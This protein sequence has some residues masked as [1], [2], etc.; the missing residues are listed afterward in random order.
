MP[1]VCYPARTGSNDAREGAVTETTRADLAARLAAGGS[2]T[3][4]R[5]G[6]ALTAAEA[7]VEAGTPAPV[8]AQALA[9]LR[10]ALAAAGAE[11]LGGGD[12]Q[13][14][15]DALV[16][17][18]PDS[19][20]AEEV[21][22]LAWVAIADH[23]ARSGERPA[24][25]TTG[26]AESWAFTARSRSWP[27]A[28]PE[29]RV[30]QAAT[31]FGK[32]ARVIVVRGPGRSAFLAAL[33]RA[34]LGAHGADAIVTPVIPAA[35]DDLQ[36]VLHGLL[37][38]ASLDPQLAA[39]LDQLQLGEDLL[40]VLGRAGEKQPVALL[41][42]DAHLQSRAVLLGL[43]IF[44][45]PAG[46]RDAL[47]AVGSADDPADDGPL[48]E[49]VA[50]AADRGLLTEI[51]LP[52]FDASGAA[53]LWT[54]RFGAAPAPALAQALAEAAKPRPG[55]TPADALRVARA[56]IEDLADA[57]DPARP[58]ADAA[59]HLARGYDP[60][61]HLP[62]HDVARRV[63]A[64]AALEGETF[65]ALTVG[66][67]FQKD[68]DFI[69][70]LLFDDEHE[71]NGTPV[72][73]CAAAV[74]PG[75][76]RWT[77]LPD[78]LHPVFC[79][80]DARLAAAL[81]PVVPDN[82]RSLVAGALRD[83]L[84]E[85]YGPAGTW[86]VADRLWRLDVLAGRTRHV[87]RLLIGTFDPAR[88]EA[89]LR[90]MAPV[91]GAEKPYRLALARLFGSAMEVGSL[92]ARQ[93]N[94]PGA[95]QAFQIAAAAAQRLGRP[96]PA[97]EAL[98]RLAELRVALALPRAAEQA[99]QLADQLLD[100]AGQPL[101]RAR[102]TLL[103]AEVAV[104][105][106]DTESALR[107]LEDA[108]AKLRALG[109][110]GHVALGLSR[111]GRLVFERGDASRAESLLDEAIGEADASADARA[112]AVA[113]LTR[114]FVAGEQGQLDVAFQRLQEAARAFQEVGLPVHLVEMAAAGLQRRHGD[115]AEAEQRL[116]RVADA[117]KKGGAALQWA[118]AWHEVARSLA[119]Q[120]KFGEA[121]AALLETVQVRQRARDRF[122]L[123][124]LHED[125]G[126][127]CRA[128][129]DASRALAE[130]A[131]GRRFAER[132]GL[133]ARLGRIDAAIAQ[134]EAALDAAPE[135]DAAALKA[136][137]LAEVDALEE[138]WRA[139][140]QPQKPAAQA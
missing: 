85:S 130:L 92:A 83:I 63:L 131:K 42:D 84:L 19:P 125:L 20:L 66:R 139:I 53:A 80:G 79:F 135:V 27:Y 97:G 10:R 41:L 38:R 107:A 88:I 35:R 67:V 64:V 128:Q 99:I 57:A 46:Q 90:R 54:A 30:A 16:A 105:D 39:A 29:G 119:D 21:L 17:A 127:S 95:D 47:L 86:Q 26:H 74:P 102:L 117:F 118:D 51:R 65:H 109:D 72:G 140:D 24:W 22:R 76:R 15:E 123:A 124:R 9:D 43:A 52:A 45:E 115:A 6:P 116:R 87:E 11:A 132:L 94:I 12:P 4:E 103:Q 138:Q 122:A 33:R 14:V 121:G 98:A 55:S 8:R 70:D 48:A 25:G 49:V 28:D 36:P 31:A 59:E 101:S 100:R 96:A 110:R 32:G 68:E 50:D 73:T 58:R 34:L 71:I 75:G 136:S 40:G 81:R 1:S 89:G 108:A 69:E 78:G 37:R 137:A 91:L 93:A 60:D 133:A 82:E 134:I 106:G 126:E 104:L 113:R 120:G 44:L 111:L 2:W 62:K 129:G 114:A 5:L 18:A 56:W 3:A 13:R 23:L 61:A 112:R 7:V 77:N